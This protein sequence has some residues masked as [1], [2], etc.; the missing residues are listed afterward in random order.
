MHIS[1]ME[2]IPT[3]NMLSEAEELCG[4]QTVRFRNAAVYLSPGA[5]PYAEASVQFPPL[6]FGHMDDATLFAQHHF[7][8]RVGDK[9]IAERIAPEFRGNDAAIAREV[10]WPLPMAPHVIDEC[11]VLAR[12]GATTWGHWLAE[13][14]PTVAL[15]ERRFPGRFRY[16]MNR[17]AAP[18]SPYQAAFM[19]PLAYYGVSPDR[20]I[21]L[22]QGQQH[23]IRRAWVT[24]PVWYG[25]H[26]HPEAMAAMRAVPGRSSIVKRL[27]VMRRDVKTRNLVNLDAVEPVLTDAGFTVTDLMGVR[28]AHQVELFRGADVIFSVL[29]SGL[30][31]IIF[32]P[33]DVRIITAGPTGWGDD[34]FYAIAQDRNARWAEIRGPGGKGRD[35]P[36]SINTDHLQEA[37][38]SLPRR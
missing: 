3:R 10:G 2:I 11:V 27:A 29:G 4:T 23:M 36:F 9:I 25:N 6:L 16:A 20:I 38:S 12:W 31:G 5:K 30:T 35:E 24:T 28:F 34:F 1:E 17:M 18:T 15:I 21:L 13:I 22:E 8:M 32:A 14:V 37:I 7:M 26:P 33:E 19:A